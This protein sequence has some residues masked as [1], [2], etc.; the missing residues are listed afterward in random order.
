[1]KAFMRGHE[2]IATQGI[3]ALIEEA[4][5]DAIVLDN[6][7]VMRWLFGNGS[8]SDLAYASHVLDTLGRPEAHA[9]PPAIWPRREALH[10]FNCYRTWRSKWTPTP[11]S[12]RLKAPFNSP[13]RFG[14]RPTTRPISTWPCVRN[15]LWRRWTPGCSTR[16]PRTVSRV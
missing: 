12:T 8:A 15:C 16:P 1:M 3:K 2:A 13:R 5:T 6:S 10:S 4:A 11:R 14:L 7:V 9:L